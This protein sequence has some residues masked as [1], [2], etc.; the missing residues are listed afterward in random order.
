MRTVIDTKMA[1]ETVKLTGEILRF[2]F[3][4]EAGSFA[5]AVIR[6][7]SGSEEVVCGPMPGAEAGRQVEL[8]GIYATHPD[9]GREFRISKC[10]TAVK[11]KRSSAGVAVAC[12]SASKY[13]I[14]SADISRCIGAFYSSGCFSDKA[15]CIDKAFDCGAY[16]TLRVAILNKI[17]KAKSE[18]SAYGGIVSRVGLADKGY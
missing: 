11:L 7:A 3:R 4:D 18:K 10:K 9:Y 17:A 1:E 16:I 14:G 12:K 13:A 15:A 2:R 8:E 6:T 5:V